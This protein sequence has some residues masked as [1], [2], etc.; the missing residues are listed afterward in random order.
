MKSKKNTDYKHNLYYFIQILNE[1]GL[2]ID[3]NQLKTLIKTINFNEKYGM[4]YMEFMKSLQDT[5]VDGLNNVSLILYFVLKL[6]T[7]IYF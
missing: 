5:R 4:S 3:G 7:K 1:V 2:L 6:H